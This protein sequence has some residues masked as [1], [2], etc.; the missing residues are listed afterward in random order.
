MQNDKGV[1]LIELMVV[2]AIFCIL[3]A[4]AIPDYLQ[5][6]NSRSASGA[7]SELFSNVQRARSRAIR[8]NSDITMTFTTKGYTISSA[9]V[10]FGDSS[11]T[12]PG[13]TSFTSQGS[14]NIVFDG[15]SNAQIVFDGKGIPKTV[16]TIDIAVNGSKRVHM[17]R[18]G[19]LRVQSSYDNGV[20]WN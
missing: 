6:M 17:T 7:V 9:G 1:T 10:G 4:L 16:S 20:T 12:L 2:I 15:S 13:K 3:V 5:W 19:A 18:L 8:S 11:Y 14:N